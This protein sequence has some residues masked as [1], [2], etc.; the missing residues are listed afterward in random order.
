MSASFVRDDAS[1]P[2]NVRIALMGLLALSIMMPVTL[3]VPILR[4]LVGERFAVSELLTSLF[5]SINM[6]GA[7]IA[8]A[9]A[10]WLRDQQ[11]NYDLAFQL[12]AGLCAVAAALCFSVRKVQVRTT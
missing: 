3:P 10:G 4:E 11:G 5:M 1:P 8:A 12:A 9:A 6:V 7:A 2:S